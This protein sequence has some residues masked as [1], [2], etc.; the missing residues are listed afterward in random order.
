METRREEREAAKE[1][2]KGERKI[3]GRRREEG[4]KARNLKRSEKR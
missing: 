4:R 2:Q 1:E 3:T